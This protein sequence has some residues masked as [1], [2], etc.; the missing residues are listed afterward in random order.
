MNY[1]CDVIIG[2]KS[3]NTDQAYT[4]QVSD[5]LGNQ[6]DI[7]KR[8]LVN[9]NN[10]LMIGLVVSLKETI[11]GNIRNIKSIMAVIDNEPIISQ[12]NIALAYWIREHYLSRFN[13]AF[14]LMYRPLS[15]IEI[16]IKDE[17]SSDGSFDLSL[18]GKWL[19][20]EQ[21][22]KE[23]NHKRLLDNFDRLI[24]DGSLSVFTRDLSFE[25]KTIEYVELTDSE[26]L[27]KLR[28]N[29]HKQKR[30]LDLLNIEGK[31]TTKTLCDE[32]KSTVK[33]LEALQSKNLI[34][35]YTE[36]NP[37]I[38]HNSFLKPL[39]TISLT[40][41]QNSII[42]SI[43][44]SENKRFLIHGVTGSGKTEIYLRVIEEVLKANKTII[45]MVPEISLTPQTINRFKQRFGERIA[46]LH[47]KLAV[48]QRNEEWRKIYAQESDIIIGARSAVFAPVKNLG[49]V[50]IDESHEE[51]YKSSSV[52]KY[53]TIEVSEKLTSLWDAKLILG[54]ATPSS[55]SYLKGMRNEY[56]IMT[57]TKRVNQLKM[58]E[59][60]II[61]MREELDRGN[62]NIFSLALQDA[63]INAFKNKEQS[64]LFLNRRGYSSFMS[65]RSCGYVVKCKRCDIS[66]TYHQNKGRLICH[67]C[68]ASQKITV[69]CPECDSQ[70]FKTFGLGTER[71]EEEAR[72]LIPDARISRVDLDT[73]STRNSFERIYNSFKKGETDILVGTQ[74]LAKGLHFPNVTVVGIVSADLTMNLP[75]YTA[76]EKS[77]QLV[78]QVSGRAGRGN[79]SGSVFVQTYDPDHYSLVYSKNND[80]KAFVKRELSLRKEFRYPPYIDIIN[81]TVLSKKE[82]IAQNFVIEKHKE[83]RMGLNDLISKRKVLMYP[84]MNNSIYKI[85]NKYRVSIIIKYKKGV[86]SEIKNCLRKILLNRSYKE[87]DISIDINPTSI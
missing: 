86:S 68:G 13:D 36:E 10:G 58:P 19:G 25:S 35:R 52:P 7:G 67:Y 87:I 32:T 40:E 56:E 23:L 34:H 65:C 66:M 9:F 60:N 24:A 12:Q 33:D 28:I 57:L 61:D 72:K 1:Y 74:M 81:I 77:Y 2:N 83:I 71:I 55:E 43:V 62:K 11:D 80:F 84:P 41:E 51:S 17:K 47:S 3:R 82:D 54:T 48:S 5:H 63:I 14:N 18:T 78:T 22:R 20:F 16:F 4:Y 59:I 70:Y 29:S 30:I 42:N 31:M 69:K 8:V 75:F 50:I 45:Y 49:I 53:D 38:R 27:K 73:T 21:I 37:A 6:V 79:K 44:K 46:V 26:Y 15:K 76:S 64:I 85:N 39:S